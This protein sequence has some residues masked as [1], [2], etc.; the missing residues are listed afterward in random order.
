MKNKCAIFWMNICSATMWIYWLTVQWDIAGPVWYSL[1]S[2]SSNKKMSL[3]CVMTLCVVLCTYSSESCFMVQGL[4]FVLQGC[5]IISRLQFLS[6]CLTERLQLESLSSSEQQIGF[7]KNR[8]GNSYAI[9]WLCRFTSPAHTTNALSIVAASVS[10]V[11][12]TNVIGRTIW[13]MWNIFTLWMA[14]STWMR[15]LDNFREMV[16]SSP[17]NW[18][19]PFVKDGIKIDAPFAAKSSHI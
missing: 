3:L 13:K 8:A 1:V 2:D 5:Y 9:R 4:S 11:L 10:V 7:W 19:F 17:V 18:V 12:F 15:T 6:N 14:L 16:T